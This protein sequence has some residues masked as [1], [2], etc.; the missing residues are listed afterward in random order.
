MYIL[1]QKIINKYSIQNTK[2]IKHISDLIRVQNSVW[3]Y[4]QI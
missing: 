4:L 1:A 2:N 3:L